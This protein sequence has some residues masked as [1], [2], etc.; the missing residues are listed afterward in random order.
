MRP[1]SAAAR[2]SSPTDELEALRHDAAAWLPRELDASNGWALRH[3]GSP[4]QK[5][6]LYKEWVLDPA[7]FGERGFACGFWRVAPA[8]RLA[9]R[10]AGSS[11]PRALS[12]RLTV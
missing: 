10:V 3:P 8:R 4:I 7:G 9:A 11:G 2:S 1:S 12:A 6:I 5:M